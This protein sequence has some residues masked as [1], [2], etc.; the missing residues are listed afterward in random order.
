MDLTGVLERVLVHGLAGES[1]EI[2][3]TRLAE[4]V[5]ERGNPANEKRVAV[6]DV[7]LPGLAASRG[8]P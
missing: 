4:F 3:L 5:T 1:F 7:E 8:I 2:P 6:V